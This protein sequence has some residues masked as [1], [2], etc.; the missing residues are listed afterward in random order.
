MI[1]FFSD[2]KNFCLDKLHNSQNNMWC[3]VSPVRMTSWGTISLNRAPLRWLHK[4]TREDLV[5]CHTSGK[6]Q[7]WLLENFYDVTHSTFGPNSSKLLCVG[8]KKDTNHTTCNTNA[9]SW[10]SR[11]RRCSKNF[12]GTQ[13]GMHE[14]GSRDILRPWSKLRMAT[15]IKFIFQP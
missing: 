5:L 7:K 6:S 3:P 13:W 14:P 9:K 2:V 8:I 4:A 15:L 12:T 11:T 1:W 10:W